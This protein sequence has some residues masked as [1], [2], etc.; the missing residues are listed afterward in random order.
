MFLPPDYNKFFDNKIVFIIGVARSGTTIIGKIIGS[1]S[2][3]HYSYE[4]S[5]CKF[6]LPLIQKKHLDYEQGSILF[7]AVLF[8]DFFLQTLHGRNVNFNKRDDSYIG[9]YSD[10]EEVKS[11]WE[12]YKRRIDV[13]NDL[14]KNN[15]NFVIKIPDIQPNLDLINEMFDNVKFIHIIRDGNDV[16]SSSIRRDF[17]SEDFLNNRSSNWGDKY[18]DLKIP[19]FIDKK[20]FE[21][22]YKWNRHTRIAYIWRTLTEKGL[23]FTKKNPKSVIEFKLEDFIQKPES[24][25]EKL[26]KFVGEIRTKI[27]QRHIASIK[28]HKNFKYADVTKLLESPEKE[29]YI[30]FR[31]KLVYNTPILTSKN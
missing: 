20:E 26:E 4:P 13:V 14:E 7:K 10:I 29:K 16:I 28:S 8:E 1:F 24:Y 15:Y 27:T 30:E 31:E 19:W 17:Y 11:R 18:N 9:N 12:K 5:S 22:F 23:E 3:T 2:D 6:I 25:V 21:N